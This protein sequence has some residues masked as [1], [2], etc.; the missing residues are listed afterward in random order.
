MQS[1]KNRYSI[2]IVILAVILVS[3]ISSNSYSQA[4][5][6]AKL[7]TDEIS[8]LTTKL[9]KKIILSDSQSKQVSTILTDY[10]KQLDAIRNTNSNTAPD[11]I[12]MKQLMTSTTDKINKLFDEKQLMKFDIIKNDW[13]K[14]LNAEA[15]E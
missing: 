15:N 7:D 6:T 12:A 9:T 3:L 8:S 1:L 14:E 10:S 13:W 2:T 4:V 5:K 11:E